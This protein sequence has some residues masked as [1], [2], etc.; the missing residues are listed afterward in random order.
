MNQFN[1]VTSLCSLP[2]VVIRRILNYYLLNKS[3]QL[4]IVWKTEHDRI[5]DF[6]MFCH[7]WEYLMPYGFVKVDNFTY[8]LIKKRYP[9]IKL[10]EPITLNKVV[11][12]CWHHLYKIV[13]FQIMIDECP[14]SREVLL[15]GGYFTYY[16]DNLFTK[17]FAD[18]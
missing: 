15:V 10:A 12:D 1:I 3:R 11:L 6:P 16:G 18:F 13:D 7:I 4:D 9:H 14:K 8:G 17:S 5:N 2:D